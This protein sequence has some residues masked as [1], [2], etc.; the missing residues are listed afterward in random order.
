[1]QLESCHDE[2]VKHNRVIKQHD[3][4]EIYTVYL[5]LAKLGHEFFKV[6]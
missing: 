5:T 2:E 4:T 3:I 6:L 1:M